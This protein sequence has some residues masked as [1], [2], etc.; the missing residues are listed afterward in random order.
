MKKPP[1]KKLT[2]LTEEEKRKKVLNRLARLEGQIK[3]IR[4][5]I[6]DQNACVDI[7]TQI[8]AIR[9]A[10]TMLGLE[11]LKE[12]FLCKRI[13]SIDEKYLETKLFFLYHLKNLCWILHP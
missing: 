2:P 1:V 4:R 6:E 7:I 10:I 13:D 11:L 9:S 5:M 8:T 12:D 3:G